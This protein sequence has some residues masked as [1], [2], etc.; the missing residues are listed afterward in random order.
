[1]RARLSRL[2]QRLLG[3]RG[4]APQGAPSAGPRSPARRADAAAEPDPRGPR[5]RSTGRLLHL[6][7]NH[8][9]LAKVAPR[10]GMKV[11]WVTSGAPVELLRAFDIMAIYP[12]NHG[13]ICGA[14]KVAGSLS[15]H[16]EQRGFSR[17][18][19]SYA[20]AD[21]GF[22][23]GGKS[24]VGGYARPDVLFCCNNICDTVVKWYEALAW[25][26]RV[27]L[28]LI[29]TPFVVAGEP[30]DHAVSYVKGQL[31]HAAEQFEA[32]VGRPLRMRRFESTL[33]LARQ[34]VTLW[35]Q[36]LEASRARPAPMNCFDA[37]VHMAPIVTL[38]G[39]HIVNDYYRALLAELRHRV[40]RGI[41]AVPGERVRLVWDN[42]PIWYEL[43]RLSRFL[44]SQKA[45]LV[46]DT[47]TTAWADNDLRADAGFEGMARVYTRVFL[48]RGLEPKT[49]SLE[50]LLHEYQ[51]DGFVMHSN[52]SCKPYS[53]GQYDM[54]R[55][56][57]A[58]TGKPGLVLEGDMA[59][60][61]H[62]ADGP[63]YNRLQAFCEQI[64]AEQ[65]A[66]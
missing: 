38:R 66:P 7:R 45:C 53:F 52:R 14:R 43:G 40:E 39:S 47:Y 65:V 10:L 51:A 64:L 11:A 37:F 63:A 31:E 19:C 55:R 22:A 34:N 5:L 61:A 46:A 62:F 56:V 44:A 59:D 48:N 29:D 8:Y 24:P 58:A 16:A 42:L 54:R 13:A 20:R 57:S 21:L 12:E 35:R 15:G 30:P 26:F 18:L 36:V 9:L 27:P 3:R 4:P 1:M 33:E 60:E 41:A 6:L 17:D 25:H 23:F 50:R 28:I 2:T 32:L 49:A